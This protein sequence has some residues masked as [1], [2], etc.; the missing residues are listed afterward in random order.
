ML[1]YLNIA[2]QRYPNLGSALLWLGI[3]AVT[4]VI[5]ASASQTPIVKRFGGLLLIATGSVYA[6]GI[7]QAALVVIGSH[8][9]D[10][11]AI[12]F[13]IVALMSVFAFGTNLVC[14]QDTTYRNGVLAV[15]GSGRVWKLID[16]FISSAWAADW[17]YYQDDSICRL[18]WKVVSILTIMGIIMAAAVV[19][20]IFTSVAYFLYNGSNP[21]S[22]WLDAM[23]DFAI[24]KTRREMKYWGKVPRSPG[25]LLLA[26]ATICGLAWVVITFAW[27]VAIVAGWLGLMVVCALAFLLSTGLIRIFDSK[28]RTVNRDRLGDA[29]VFGFFGG[30]AVSSNVF[31]EPGVLQGSLTMVSGIL[32]ILM[33]YSWLSDVLNK[34]KPIRGA[35]ESMPK[36]AVE[37]H[38]SAGPYEPFPEPKP[39][40]L[41]QTAG[42]TIAFC[43][44]T[45]RSTKGLVCPRIKIV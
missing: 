6:F 35:L 9:A 20:N 34:G 8:W 5:L 39:N 26:L 10:S 37:A 19:F 25:L 1:Q 24:E 40:W 15:K 16:R 2:E 14:S 7:Y 28:E 12:S 4:A 30:I 36:D 42:D 3:I 29:V 13:V 41:L 43:V 27:V 33:L 44:A 31:L 17:N 21:V 32:A 23:Q 11:Y 18:S 45:L 22:V 38:P